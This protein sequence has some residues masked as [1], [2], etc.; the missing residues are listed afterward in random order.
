MV[1]ASLIKQIA[2][3]PVVAFIFTVGTLQILEIRTLFEPPFLFFILNVVFIFL[4]SIVVAF[5]SAKAYLQDG[6]LVFLYL[7]CA[8]LFFA[9]AVIPSGLLIA[10]PGGPNV[11]VTIYNT[12]ALMSSIFHALG[13]TLVTLGV[14][15]SVSRLRRTRLVLVLLGAPL[16]TLLITVASLQGITPVYFV[17]GQGPTLV[18]QVVIGAATALFAISSLLFMRVYS[19][20]KIDTL[21]WYS[22]ALALSAIGM[23]AL[24]VTKATGSPQAWAGRSAVYVAGV[25]FLV[26]VL[27][28]VRATR[29]GG[30]QSH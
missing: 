9:C 13:A 3:I 12:G 6:S 27:T 8:V 11:A 10:P 25:Y 30:T 19:K 24:F 7:T 1:V 4:A 16:F 15:A 26:S 29:A 28:T 18:R 20:S 14:T 17:Q 2:A 21:F 5:L 22:L 23:Y